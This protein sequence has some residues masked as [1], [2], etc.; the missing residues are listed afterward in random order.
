[1]LTSAPFDNWWH[2]A[3][4]LDVRIFSPPHVVLASGIA[5]IQFG[6]MLMV[7]ACQNRAGVRS[8][9][10]QLLF[11]YAAALLLVNAGTLVAEYIRR[12]EMHRSAFYQITCGGFPFLLVGIA[13]AS[14]ARWRATAAAALYTAV[15]IAMVW[16]LPLFEGRPLLGPIYVQVERFI[17]P[18]PPL[19]LLAP[20]LAIDLMLRRWAGSDWLL[21]G[22]V[23]SAFLVI[24]LAVQWPFAEFLMSPWARN[25]IF[26]T[27]HIPY[28]VPPGLQERWFQLNAPDNLAIGL[29]IAAALA[30]ASARGGLWWGAWMSRVQR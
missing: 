27:H 30:F 2:N 11:L 21:A 10:L 28:M 13:R 19:L 6:A 23:G 5:G 14:S 12:W 16:I 22:A 4:G 8:R 25:W 7:I 15:L 3:Y 17:P 1:M 20:A 24:F 9:A 26:G 29:S 18:E